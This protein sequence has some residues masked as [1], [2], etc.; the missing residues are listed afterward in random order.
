MSLGRYGPFGGQYV[1]EILVQPLK[2]LEQGFL[3]LVEEGF[4]E[5]FH[6]QLAEYGGRPTPLTEVPRFAQA[7][8]GPRIFL[9]REDLLH[10]GAHKLNNALGQCLLAKHLG[11]TRVICETGAG[12][13]GVAT[14][15]ACARL[16]LECVV[17]MGALDVQR[18]EPN[19]KRI[20]LL[21][22]EVIA[23]DQGGG[24]LKDAINEALRDWSASFEK[25]HYCLG[26][27]LGPHP[28]P[29]IVKTFQ[30]V[31][32][33]ETQEQIHKRIGRDPDYLVACVGGGSNAIGFFTPFLSFKRVQMIGVEAG[34]I[35]KTEGFHAARF[36]SQK[37]GVLHGCYTYLLQDEGG[38]IQA[39][40]SVSAG[41]DYPAI[42]PEHAYLFE[43]K[44]V[45]YVSVS[46]QQA[47]EAM[48]LLSKTE[49]IIPALES[50][51]AL[52]YLVEVGNT[53]PSDAVIILNLSG[54]GDKDLPQLFSILGE[55][56][57]TT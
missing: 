36:S 56:N 9:K 34:G 24:I 30:L 33:T 2:E 46:D 10:T 26:S 49:G 14:A 44:R 20:K 31:I 4:L 41:L 52:A 53:L 42:G 28:F 16:G 55:K 35:D 23:V 51:H 19:V 11:K 27:A 13:H 7:I 6:A 57:G 12:Q 45:E 39:T 50:S 25:T 15:S 32:G 38:Q 43:S 5:S 22:A 3:K 21:G 48:L 18:Q 17:Y 47:I 29:E 40:H 1:P 37:K 8:Q 54:R